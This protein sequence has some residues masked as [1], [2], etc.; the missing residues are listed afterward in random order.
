M[1][2]IALFHH[3]NVIKGDHLL[4]LDMKRVVQF[5]FLLSLGCTFLIGL[6]GCTNE[7]KQQDNSPISEEL[8]SLTKQF[9][10]SIPLQL[11]YHQQIFINGDQKGAIEGLMKLAEKNPSRMDLLNELAVLALQNKDTVLSIYYL[12][13]SI[14]VNPNQSDA[15]FM[16]GGIYAAQKNP[17]WKKITEHLIQQKE[18]L[19]ASSRGYYLYGIQLANDN[20]I[21]EA[22]AAF[23]SAIIQNFTFVDAYIEK[24]ILLY[25]TDQTDQAIDLLYKALELNR[26]SAD[27][28]FWLGEC[29]LKKKNHE[30]ALAF[31]EQTLQLDP[32]YQSATDRIAKIKH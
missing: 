18:D 29:Y 13:R 26:K 27:I 8:S 17:N 32:E 25:D 6:W 30:K 24:A 15:A 4:I 10:D 2:W 16:L 9:P 28:P 20:R 3:Q 21:K 11:Q 12:N 31:F 23:D 5:T 7:K 1:K 22:I 14:A 19:V